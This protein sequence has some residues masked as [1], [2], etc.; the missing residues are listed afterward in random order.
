RFPALSRLPAEHRQAIEFTMSEIRW[1]LE[2]ELVSA[3][4]HS[5]VITR[6]ILRKV[7]SHVCESDGRPH[8]HRELVQLQFVFGPENSLQ[9]FKEVRTLFI[10]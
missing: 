4:R 6:S 10:V 5:R 2:D 3:L 8:C 9:K 7:L 1:L